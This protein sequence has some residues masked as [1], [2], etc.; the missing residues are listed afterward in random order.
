MKRTFVVLSTAAILLIGMLVG[1]VQPAPTSTPLPPA[2][3][4]SILDV[5]GPDGST[6]FSLADLKALPATEGQ[7]GTKCVCGT[8]TPPELYKGV[9]LKD[10]VAVIGGFDESM[11]VNVLA[12]DGYSRAFSHDQVMTG[13]FTAYDPD[14]GDELKSHDPLTAILVYER[15]GQPLDAENDGT[16]RL[17]IVSAK[18]NQITDA[19]WSVKWVTALEIKSPWDQTLTPATSA[20]ESDLVI[21]GLV[22]EPLGLTEAGLR[23]M[24]VAQI[25]AE[26][27]K[28][29][30]QEYEGVRLNALLDQVGVQSDATKLVITAN[31][32]FTARVFLA[33][34]RDCADCLVAFTED[35]GTFRMVMPALPS[36]VWIK[37]V[38]KIEIK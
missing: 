35:P 16:L 13:S 26:H 1:C 24:V 36:N 14:T 31:D 38:V 34:V 33:E 20:V 28:K 17:L 37:G 2:L 21:V 30:Q 4:A 19:L 18:N 7:G 8:I 32:G 5:I 10:L 15:D 6:S 9:A 22:D 12:Q 25:T 29:G 27:P 11:G 3:S 23:E